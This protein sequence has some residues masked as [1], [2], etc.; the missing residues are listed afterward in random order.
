MNQKENRVEQENQNG[1][2]QCSSI[3]SCTV[4]H[5]NNLLQIMASIFYESTNKNDWYTN[6]CD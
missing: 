5:N 3:M 2:N 6:Y 4:T 1:S